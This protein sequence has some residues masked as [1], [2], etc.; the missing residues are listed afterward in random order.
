MATQI[1]VGRPLDVGRGWLAVPLWR[2]WGL[3]RSADLRLDTDLLLWAL[4]PAL[5][6]VAVAWVTV[7]WLALDRAPLFYDPVDHV[8]LAIDFV[9]NPVEYLSREHMWYP[10]FVHVLLGSALAATGYDLDSAIAMVNLA[11]FAVLL[12]ATFAIGAELWSPRVGAVAA[13]LLAFYP[14]TF[15]H[16]RFPMLDLPL[17]AMVAASMFALIRS[18]S[19]QDRRWSVAFGVVAGLGCLTKQSYVFAMALPVLYAVFTTP[20]RRQTFANLALAGLLA[21]LIALPWYAPRL[22][23]FLGPWANEQSQVAKT[24]HD[25]ETFTLFGLLYYVIGTWHQTSFF[26]ALLWLLTVPFFLR[27]ERRVLVMLWWVGAVGLVSLLVN[28]DGRYLMP[29]LPAIA[30]MT[31]AGLCRLPRSSAAVAAVAAFGAVQLWAVSFGVSWL[32]EGSPVKN[33]VRPNESVQPFAQNYLLVSADRSQPDPSGWGVADGLADLRGYVGVVGDK[34][35]Y[36][37]A[38]LPHL[39]RAQETGYRVTS[40]ARVGCQDPSQLQ[41]FDFVVVQVGGPGSLADPVEYDRCTAG[42]REVGRI[43]VATRHLLK[44]VSYLAVFRPVDASSAA[45]PP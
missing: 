29:V 18:R 26:F 17:A 19:F 30:L 16:L 39:L 11:F 44:G 9:N 37:A 1:D 43:P 31:A 3:F 38:R 35:I 45:S 40:F 5:T 41:V 20:R 33:G 25:P 23:W 15:V 24:E 12:A 10:P 42:L 6:F 8:S 32:P 14:A 27:S 7:I 28:K 4:I 34:I 21:V 13:L 2:R 36:D 22:G